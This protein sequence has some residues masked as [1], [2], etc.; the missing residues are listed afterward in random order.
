MIFLGFDGFDA[1]FDIS[2][3]TK[4][5]FTDFFQYRLKLIRS[6]CYDMGTQEHFYKCKIHCE[7][8]VVFVFPVSSSIYFVL[9]GIISHYSSF[10]PND[11][12]RLNKETEGRQSYLEG[13]CSSIINH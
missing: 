6:C 1:F 5:K 7:S 12:E 9:L 11:V 3:N 4:I 8:L 13:R 10:I 2:Q